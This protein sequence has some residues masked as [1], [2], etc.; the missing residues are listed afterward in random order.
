MANAETVLPLVLDDAAFLSAR[1][2]HGIRK[3]FTSSQQH[4][5]LS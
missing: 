5:T 2:G 1:F 4:S 3:L